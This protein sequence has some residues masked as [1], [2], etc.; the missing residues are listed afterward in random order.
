MRGRGGLLEGWARP[1]QDT[2][3]PREPRRSR[4][5]EE[6]GTASDCNSEG[7]REALESPDAPTRFAEMTQFLKAELTVQPGHRRIRY[8][9]RRRLCRKKYEPGPRRPH[10]FPLVQ[11]GETRHS[12]HAFLHERGVPSWSF[13]SLYCERTAPGFY[14]DPP[15]AGVLHV[16]RTGALKTPR[17]QT[18]AGPVVPIRLPGPA[19]GWSSERVAPAENRCP[20][21]PLSSGH[22]D[23]LPHPEPKRSGSRAVAD[24]RPPE[25]SCPSAS[26]FG[27][28][29]QELGRW[30]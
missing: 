8:R 14:G 28:L 11:L 30:A 5:A 1:T 26:V 22:G 19:P 9:T 25:P 3:P 18:Q 6:T 15:E 24:S 12:R 27:G 4:R 13:C 29:C 10:G 20:K 23:L 16:G 7:C 21:V 17:A 2:S